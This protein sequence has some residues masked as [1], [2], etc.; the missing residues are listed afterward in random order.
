MT[1]RVA[2]IYI[3]VIGICIGILTP[4]T[5]SAGSN[6]SAGTYSSCQF[7]SCGITLTSNG[8]VNL[9]TIPSAASSCTISSDTVSVFTDSSTGYVLTI[10]DNDISNSMSGSAGGT[11]SPVAGSGASPSTIS[12]N[13]WGYRVDNILGFGAGPTAAT[14]NTAIPSLLFAPVPLSSTAGDILANS[15]S[16]ADPAIA[17]PVWFGLC[18]NVSIPSGVYSDDVVYTAVVN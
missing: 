6:Y 3:G 12:S 15:S 8:S 14:S 9:D 17:T 11:I 2:G 18:A 5:A 4:F 7:N 10:N 1:R 16:A 13:T